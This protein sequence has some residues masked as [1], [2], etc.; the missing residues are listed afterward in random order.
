MGH[1]VFQG[2]SCGH[3]A[4]A[5]IERYTGKSAPVDLVNAPNEASA[6]PPPPERTP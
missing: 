2:A 1:G 6:L 5:D 3:A 4:L